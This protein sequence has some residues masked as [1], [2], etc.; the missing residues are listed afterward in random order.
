MSFFYNFKDIEII[1]K[2]FFR[3]EFITHFLMENI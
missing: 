1:S 3:I 2:F